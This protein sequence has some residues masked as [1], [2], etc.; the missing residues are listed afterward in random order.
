MIKHTYRYAFIFSTMKRNEFVKDG[1]PKEVD[2]AIELARRAQADVHSGAWR[3]HTWLRIRQG[4]PTSRTD[5]W[6]HS[7][8]RQCSIAR[9]ATQVPVEFRPQ[10]SRYRTISFAFRLLPW[11]IS[12]NWR[13]SRPTFSSVFA[14]PGRRGHRCKFDLAKRSYARTQRRSRG[15]ASLTRSA[16][17]S[18]SLPLR[19]MTAAS[20]SA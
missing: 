11:A 20:A 19:F 17:P 16:R 4:S 8:D 7:P 13:L 12:S 14:V 5:S 3:L 10:R 1:R 18:R 15:R 6:L 9:P 2:E